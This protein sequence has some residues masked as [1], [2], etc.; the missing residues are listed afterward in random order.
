MSLDGH[1]HVVSLDYSL[2]FDRVHP[3]LALQLLRSLGLNQ[4][5]F[6]VLLQVWGYQQRFLFWIHAFP[7]NPK[8]LIKAFPG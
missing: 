5:I 6:S 4:Q 1:A 2:A 7:P 3:S 8:E